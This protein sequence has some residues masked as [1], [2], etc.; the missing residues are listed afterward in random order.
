M[1]V[2]KLDEGKCTGCGICQLACSAVKEGVFNPEIACVQIHSGYGEDGLTVSGEFCDMCLKCVETCPTEAISVVDGVLSFD[3][4]SCTECGLCE[5]VCPHGV[6][7]MSPSRKVM[8]CD[9]CGECLAWCP[10][11]AIYKE[12]VAV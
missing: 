1:A 11:E 3:K 8:I 7:H 2:L 12:K 10:H 5:D 4:E 6:I 9:Q